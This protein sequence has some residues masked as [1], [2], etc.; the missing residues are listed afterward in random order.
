LI[1]STAYP[2]P[3]S[4]GLRHRSL[5][6]SN[7]KREL[8]QPNFRLS[9]SSRWKRQG[10]NIQFRTAVNVEIKKKRPLRYPSLA[11]AACM[12]TGYSSETQKRRID[13]L[14]TH[15]LADPLRMNST[16]SVSAVI[17]LYRQ[18][19]IYHPDEFRELYSHYSGSVRCH[20]VH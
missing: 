1:E 12:T 14:S 15:P 20:S 9:Y 2:T 10:R 6:Y 19:E 5:Y 16:D 3:L 18:S 8:A 4:N 13:A 11:A 7:E 17:D